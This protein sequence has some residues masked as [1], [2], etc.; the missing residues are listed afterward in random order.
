MGEVVPWAKEK[1]ERK[2]YRKYWQG[3]QLTPP[4]EWCGGCFKVPECFPV[5]LAASFAF[6]THKVSDHQPTK[7]SCHCLSLTL[8]PGAVL[9][10]AAEPLNHCQHSK[11]ATFTFLSSSPGPSI[12]KTPGTVRLIALNL[13]LKLKKKP[14]WLFFFYPSKS[15]S[16]T[17]KMIP[18][19]SGGQKKKWQLKQRFWRSI[20]RKIRGNDLNIELLLQHPKLCSSL[21][22]LLEDNREN[23]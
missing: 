23:I 8:A 6:K 2:T 5:V 9:V 18:L 3:V 1:T 14:N 11:P 12:L 20:S 7:L 22:R 17:T 15:C 4:C 16:D 21:Q 10:N 13:T 19:T